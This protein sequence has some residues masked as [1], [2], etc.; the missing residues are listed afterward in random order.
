MLKKL[1]V[2]VVGVAFCGLVSFAA[3]A[4]NVNVVVVDYAKVLEDAPQAIAANKRLE[5]EF[6]PRNAALISLR[7]KLHDAEERL[8]KEGASMSQSQLRKIERDIRDR[9]REIKRAQ[10]DYRDDLTLRRNE[11]LQNIQK[12]INSAIESLAK[13]EKYDIILAEG[14]IHAS[15]KVNI[16]KKVIKALQAE[17]KSAPSGKK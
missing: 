7:K 15:A 3:V 9:K 2:S 16:T 5:K 17:M 11:E 10:E 1:I 4:E 6:E 14:V 13:K 12:R 8:A